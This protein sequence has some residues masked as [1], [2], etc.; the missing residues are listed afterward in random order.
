MRCQL[1][2]FRGTSSPST[3]VRRR[4]TPAFVTQLLLASCMSAGLMV[5]SGCSNLT[6]IL[7]GPGADTKHEP[8]SLPDEASAKA[9]RP[10]SQGTQGQGTQDCGKSTDAH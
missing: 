2:V 7:G 8:P 5:L 1:S 6:Q 3:R 10:C 9:Q 4:F